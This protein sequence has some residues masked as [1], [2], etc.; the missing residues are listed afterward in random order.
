MKQAEIQ[1]VGMP[2]DHIRGQLHFL[3]TIC[4]TTSSHAMRPTLPKIAFA[5]Q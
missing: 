4:K 1:L 3:L 2:Q 5:A